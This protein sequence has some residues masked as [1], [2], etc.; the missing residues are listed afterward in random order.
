MNTKCLIVTIVLAVVFQNAYCGVPAN[1]KARAADSE[2]DHDAGLS[3][4]QEQL[5]RG[6]T[7]DMNNYYNQFN[8][9]NLK[10]P[11]FNQSSFQT[12]NYSQLNQQ[13]FQPPS[14][15]QLNQSSFQPPSFSQF[16]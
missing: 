5:G 6:F 16:N 11:S 10:P 9:Q 15:S 14:Y 4:S 12:P 1:R 7:D 2:L 8:Q 13:N 3:N